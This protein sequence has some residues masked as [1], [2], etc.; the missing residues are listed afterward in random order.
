[1]S[2]VKNAVLSANQ[3]LMMIGYYQNGKYT[4]TPITIKI[5]PSPCFMDQ[6][7]RL[8]FSTMDVEKICFEVDPEHFS[9]AENDLK[10]R[11]GDGWKL[12]IC[13]CIRSIMSGLDLNE[14]PNRAN[15]YTKPD[16]V[17]WTDRKPKV[18]NNQVYPTIIGVDTLLVWVPPKNG[19]LFDDEDYIEVDCIPVYGY[20]D[21]PEFEF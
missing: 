2:K 9:D 3:V 13:E 19:E 8:R 15:E 18:H 20:T 5:R 12:V 1:M 6:Q 10:T 7:K 4:C 11:F 16:S 21:Q 14:F 17:S